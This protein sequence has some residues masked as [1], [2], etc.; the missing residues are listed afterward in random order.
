MSKT[1]ELTGIVRSLPDNTVPDGTMQEVINLRPKDGAWR[2]VGSKVSGVSV[3]TNVRCI[4]TVNESIKN[5][6]GIS[7]AGNIMFWEYVDGVL[8]QS[9]VDTG[10][11]V[12]T[13]ELVFA[14]MN[15]VLMMSNNTDNKTLLFLFDIDK[16]TY[17]SFDGSLPELP[18]ITISVQEG[19][20]STLHP[21]DPLPY[22]YTD[23][24]SNLG[25]MIKLCYTQSKFMV[26][27]P[28]L[29]R[30]A[31]E[32]A[33]GSIVMQSLPYYL[34]SVSYF[35]FT[36]GTSDITTSKPSSHRDSP[37]TLM[38]ITQIKFVGQYIVLKT[39]ASIAD[40]TA[41]KTKYKGIIASLNVYM[42]MPT[43]LKDQI[44]GHENTDGTVTIIH[45][46]GYDQL[47]I[48]TTLSYYQ[49]QSI[50][51][52]DFDSASVLAGTYNAGGITGDFS[53]LAAGHSTMPV[54]NYTHH[55]MHGDSIF[56]YNSRI[57]LCN[58]TT[59]LYKGINNV[60]NFSEL[61]QYSKDHYEIGLEYD[62]KTNDG[63]KT[64]FSGWK[65]LTCWTQKRSDPTGPFY[66]NFC[67]DIIG[68]P[69]SRAIKARIYARYSD[70]I[71]LIDTKKLDPLP[72]LN[73][74]FF[75]AQP[76]TGTIRSTLDDNRTIDYN[77]VSFTDYTIVAALP[78]VD[79][80][81]YDG[82]RIQ[83]TELSNPFYYP[84]INSYRVGNGRVLGLSTNAIALSQ[85]QFGSFPIF[86][87][88]TDGIWTMS[89]GNGETLINTISPLSRLVCNNA[90]S[91]T[92]IDGGSAFTTDKGL[93]IISGANPFEISE[94]AEGAYKSKLDG[95]ISYQAL[96][97][98]NGLS[99]FLCSASILT[100]ISDAIM[101]WD[102]INGELIISNPAYPYSW[103]CNPKTKMWYKISEVFSSFV[104]DFPKTY[105][106]NAISDN[107]IGDVY[108]RYDISE[109]TYSSLVPVLMETR[110]MKFSP[111]A[112]KKVLR[113]MLNGCINETD[114][115]AFSVSAFGSADGHTWFPLNS[116]SRF[117][118]NTQLL[119]GRSSFSCRYYIIVACGH[120]DQ[121][122]YFTHIEVDYEDRYNT[123]LR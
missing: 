62:I 45:T 90:K 92:P 20:L 64:V 54:D 93:F 59:S 52:D 41:F 122:A 91:I 43:T 51:L 28:V 118:A 82:N 26:S 65:T 17:R 113:L 46:P 96:M 24:D 23:K 70:I 5:Y 53:D 67:F 110:P 55:V 75:A 66:P 47:M 34:D 78:A 39:N 32:L 3:P 106:Y 74:A 79:D 9:A 120:I 116:S 83:A 7:Q 11:T 33:D 73:F 109:E 95:S 77:E 37:S 115:N 112:F 101:A 76:V 60:Y 44:K 103:V 121:Y 69:D 36:D 58:I 117:Q 30:F 56:A 42:S 1:I 72:I 12:G 14:Q 123:K 114:D 29:L 98:K 86:A 119:I 27:G 4:H 89:I 10:I 94:A 6:I 71:Y 50:A 84:A 48:E 61:A 97:V 22:S 105:A 85:G 2:P 111:A 63:V 25:N 13:D 100:Y 8:T 80:T 31:W 15:N 107:T 57:F 99:S 40:R 108:R 49:I 87:F 68:Y 19:D 81:Y 18:D 88:C 21:I 104:T 38:G 16:N 35:T 102:H